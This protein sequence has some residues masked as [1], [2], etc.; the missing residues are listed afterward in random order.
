[1]K[2]DNPQKY[3]DVLQPIRF[4]GWMEAHDHDWDDVRALGLNVLMKEKVQ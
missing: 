3:E 4:R 1:M 2:L